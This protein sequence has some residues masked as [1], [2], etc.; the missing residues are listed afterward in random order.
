MKK[1]VCTNDKKLPEGAELVEGKEYVVED[2]FMNNFE[3]K[4]YI[5][6]GINNRGRTKTGFLWYGYDA[7]RFAV[8]DGS[9]V[10]EKE[11]NFALN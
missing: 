3:Q 9:G 8:L 7:M 6:K 4:V 11:Y 5:L 10:E 1:V 2:E